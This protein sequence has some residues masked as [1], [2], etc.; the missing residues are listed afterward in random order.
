[1]RM[2][3]GDSQGYTKGRIYA[4]LPWMCG[5]I[6]RDLSPQV[7]RG[8]A[9][10]AGTPLLPWTSAPP[11]PC[12]AG[13]A[14]RE[15]PPSIPRV[16][17]QHSA[18]CRPGVPCV[19]AKAFRAVGQAF[20]AYGNV[21]YVNA[22]NARRNRA[23]ARGS[24]VCALF[25]CLP[26]CCAA[27][28]QSHGTSGRQR[29]ER[30][31]S[32]ARNASAATAANAAPRRALSNYWRLADH[33]RKHRQTIPGSSGVPALPAWARPRDRSWEAAIALQRAADALSRC[34]FGA[35][36]KKSQRHARIK[37]LAQWWWIVC[38]LG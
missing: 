19:A 32:N 37:L 16:A 5:P 29:T 30:L 2:R 27:L 24:C 4:T 15:L 20:R 33:P 14:F 8:H 21:V 17:A 13:Q 7:N 35:C 6:L 1:M 38:A 12:V 34:H 18:R 11:L 9:G 22:R 31:A 26:P 28:R 3:S 36:Q 10:S 25:W 23:P